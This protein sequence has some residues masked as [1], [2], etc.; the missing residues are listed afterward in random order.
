MTWRLRA[1]FYLFPPTLVKHF[2]SST[3]VYWHPSSPNFDDEENDEDELDEY[4]NMGAFYYQDYVITAKCVYIS[5][6]QTWNSFEIN[7]NSS[8]KTRRKKNK[9]GKHKGNYVAPPSTFGLLGPTYIGFLTRAAAK[10]HP[11]WMHSTHP[12]CFQI[13]VMPRR[14]EWSLAS[15]GIRNPNL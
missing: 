3:V 8:I 15:W 4:E 13:S 9:L 1:G 11:G 2:C 7:C 6:P 14:R 12:P 5:F 10:L